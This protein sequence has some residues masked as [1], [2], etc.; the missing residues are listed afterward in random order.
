MKNKIFTIFLAS[1]AL[2]L[3]ACNDWL[4]VRSKTQEPATEM[5]LTVEG[6]QDALTGCYIKMKAASLYGCD[7][8]LTTT[9][10]LAQHWDVATNFGETSTST[11]AAAVKGYKYDDESVKTAFQ[12]IY[13][14]LYN[15]I[16]QANTILEA[17]PKTGATAILDEQMRGVIEA[18]AL[19]IRAYCQFD[20]LRLFGQVPGGTKTVR[21]PYTEE[22][23]REPVKYYDFADYGKK[24]E[25]DLKKAET[26]LAKYDPFVEY[27][28]NQ[29][30]NTG[31]GSG[32]ARVENEFLKY[33]QLRLNYYAVKALQAR[34]YLYIG[35]RN[36]D[37]LAAAKVVIDASLNDKGFGLNLDQS[38][39]S[40]GYYAL[41]GQGLFM[42]SNHQLKIDMT[43]LFR[44]NNGTATTNTNLYMAPEKL[45]EMYG[46]PL[47]S[48]TNN[49]YNLLWSH[50]K[51]DQFGKICPE[52]KKYYQGDDATMSSTILLLYK[53]VVP[54]IRL[55]EMYLIVMELGN[56]L[57]EIN[58]LYTIWLKGHD[59][60]DRLPFAS[61]NEAKA[62]VPK[63]Y[64]REF[65]GEGQ[66]F[67]YYKRTFASKMLWSSRTMTENEYIVP[68]PATEFEP[69]L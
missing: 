63:E 52:L 39:F 28:V 36:S 43:S 8:I 37:A 23:S 35:G 20:I 54:M 32:V 2:L 45:E 40:G 18:E 14:E 13:G 22:V 42:L 10:Y 68:L 29:V 66:M 65:F 26:L 24:I 34:F 69:N 61:I 25:D 31:L 16:V 48:S 12:S 50:D 47:N 7:M 17:M 33:R 4:D 41:P 62:E 11:L 27:T 21:L 44:G 57:A 9:E 51:K 60:R 1:L 58:D 53:Q 55:S 30:N 3:T 49:R 56:D 64:R 46:E 59:I 19:A 5:F 15:T 6:Y 38:N 67:Y